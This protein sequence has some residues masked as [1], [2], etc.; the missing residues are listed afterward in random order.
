[1]STQFGCGQGRIKSHVAARLQKIA[2]VEGFDFIC[3]EGR[4]WFAGP[5]R[6]E[7]FDGA[8][9]RDIL[10]AAKADG[11]QCWVDDTEFTS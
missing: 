7:P 6:G 2:E 5:H 1:V 11:V 3:A 9:R 4:Y 10:A 8:Y